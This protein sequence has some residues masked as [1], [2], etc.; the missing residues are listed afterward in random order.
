MTLIPNHVQ[1]SAWPSILQSASH[2][3][4]ASLANCQL[5]IFQNPGQ[6]FSSRKLAIKFLL[7]PLLH[8]WLMCL[9]IIA[10]ITLN[11]NHL[12]AVSIRLLIPL[13][14]K[15][16]LLLPTILRHSANYMR[17]L[18][19]I[20]EWMSMNPTRVY[21]IATIKVQAPPSAS[22]LSA[23]LISPKFWSTI[24]IMPCFTSEASSS[25]K[26]LPALFSLL[27]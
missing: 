23:F 20:N 22:S 14:A 17:Y 26:L 24:L 19:P 8:H 3:T 15:K 9:T 6:L 2:P 13:K 4:P 7:H 21:K 18:I 25:C 12:P 16:L 27:L 1:S 11:C 5:L 10:L